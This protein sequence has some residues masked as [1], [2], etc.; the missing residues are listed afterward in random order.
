MNPIL[1]AGL[2][3]GVFCGLWTFVMGFT[4]WYKD[5]ALLNLFFLVIAIEVGLLYVGLRKTAAV[6]TF[7]Q[8]VVAGST[9]AVIAAAIIFAGSL[10]FTTVAFPDYFRELEAAGRQALKAQGL[11][12]Q[13][14]SARLE[15]MASSSLA[16]A[17]QGAV[18]TIVTGFFASVIIG[19][20]HRT[21]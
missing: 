20:I 8:Q 7:G 15:Q 12:D 21:R 19:A 6:N 1:A 10:A 13:E 2:L 14:V 18:G 4:G 16:Q 11:S 17:T 5:P 3:I 9:M